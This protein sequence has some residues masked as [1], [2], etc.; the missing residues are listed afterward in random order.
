MHRSRGRAECQ[1][2]SHQHDGEVPGEPMAEEREALERCKDVNPDE[3]RLC[4]AAKISRFLSQA[5]GE[6]EC[7][8]DD[9]ST[10][11]DG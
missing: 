11:T 3:K 8:N 2:A 9:V 4:S 6:A 10:Q 1:G 7:G 5:R